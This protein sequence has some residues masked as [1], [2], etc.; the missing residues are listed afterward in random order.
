M[1]WGRILC[2]SSLLLQ[3]LRLKQ[4]ITEQEEIKSSWNLHVNWV[5]FIMLDSAWYLRTVNWTHILHSFLLRLCDHCGRWGDHYRGGE[6]LWGIS[7]L[8]IQKD[9]RAYWLWPYPGSD[10]FRH[11][12]INTL[13]LKTKYFKAQQE[14]EYFSKRCLKYLI[15][16][17]TEKKLTGKKEHEKMLNDPGSRKLYT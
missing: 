13:I 16:L 17:H 15:G 9:S 1:A 3:T 10:V 7:V 5:D 2:P 12:F 14:N 4:L 6:W 8:C 11:S